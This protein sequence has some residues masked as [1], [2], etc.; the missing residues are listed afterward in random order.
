MFYL[1]TICST[2]KLSHVTENDHQLYNINIV[3]VASAAAASHNKKVNLAASLKNKGLEDTSLSGG[4]MIL[5]A[6]SFAVG[7]PG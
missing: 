1:V 3:G 2:T 5:I 6:Q 4:E 7:S